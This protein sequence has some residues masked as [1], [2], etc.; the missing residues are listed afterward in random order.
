MCCGSKSLATEQL[1]RLHTRVD[2]LL[3][4]TAPFVA[5]IYTLDAFLQCEI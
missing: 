3:L 4:T 5:K 2:Y 1:L